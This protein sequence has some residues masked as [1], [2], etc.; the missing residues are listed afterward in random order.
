MVTGQHPISVEELLR[1]IISRFASFARQ[2]I[3][4]VLGT[5]G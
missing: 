5:T 2:G 4:R 1:M 3:I